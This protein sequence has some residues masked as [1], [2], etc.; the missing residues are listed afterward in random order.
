[1][2]AVEAVNNRQKNRLFEKLSTHFDGDLKG[3]TIALWGLSFKPQTNDMREATSRVVM[4]ALWD[5][6]AAVQ[7][8]DPQ[9]MQ[10][11]SRLYPDQDGLRL[12][13]TAYEA[14]KGAD[15]LLIVTE[16]QEFRSPD[17][18]LIKQ[19]LT[20]PVIIDGRNIYDPHLLQSMGISYYGI[21][22][23]HSV[24]SIGYS[25]PDRRSG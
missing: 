22:R 24:K 2:E 9:A 14:L 6:G 15:A 20:D 16:W 3:K 21:G 11:T 8:Y 25:G 10:E 23:G 12:C 5:A 1:M 18:D 4:E 7:A 13:E 19:E 17:F